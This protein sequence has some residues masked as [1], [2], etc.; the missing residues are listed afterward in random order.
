MMQPAIAQHAGAVEL[1]DVDEQSGVVQVRFQGACVGCSMSHVTLH[2]GIER[3]LKER[4]PGVTA[5]QAV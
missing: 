1:V 2:N 4:V 3:I 5:V